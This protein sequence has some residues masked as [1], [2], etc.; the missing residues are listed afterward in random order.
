MKVNIV[1]ATSGIYKYFTE[2][3]S[4]RIFSDLIIAEQL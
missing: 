1:T 4:S 3:E 2:P